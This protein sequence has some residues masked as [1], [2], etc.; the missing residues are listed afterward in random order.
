MAHKAESDKEEHREEIAV[1]IVLRDQIGKRDRMLVRF[2]QARGQGE[3][4]RVRHVYRVATDEVRDVKDRKEGEDQQRAP[5]ELRSPNPPLR[6]R[7]ALQIRTGPAAGENT[8][9]FQVRSRRETSG[10]RKGDADN[11]RR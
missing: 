8:F 9:H 11:L 3:F 5:Y 2:Y 7:R 10:A 1:L 6:N 4:V